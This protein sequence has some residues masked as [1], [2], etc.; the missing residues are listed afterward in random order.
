MQLDVVNNHK[1]LIYAAAAVAAAAIPLPLPPRSLPH[2]HR[3][4]GRAAAKPTSVAAAKSS[5]QLLAA[6]RRL[7][8]ARQHLD[9]AQQE[10]AAFDRGA[11]VFTRG[12]LGGRGAC[13]GVG[14]SVGG[15]MG[16]GV[17]LCS[18]KVQ[19]EGE[20]HLVQ[21]G[22]WR[23]I[24]SYLYTCCNAFGVNCHS[25]L[26]LYWYAPACMPSVMTHHLCGC[27][28][29]RGDGGAAARGAAAAGQEAAD[30]GCGV[31]AG[32]GSVSSRCQGRPGQLQ[33]R[34]QEQVSGM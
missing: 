10:L 32:H 9:I 15:W 17:E 20:Q 27:R 16:W 5:I 19:I 26:V 8:A 33:A 34:C 6:Q 14:V 25:F 12:T 23:R 4:M 11:V 24:L 30:P 13:V 28:H 21:G 7:D 22:C 29:Q 3:Q 1:P 18:E 31:A 2:L